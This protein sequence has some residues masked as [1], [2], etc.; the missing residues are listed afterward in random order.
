MVN[1]SLQLLEYFYFTADYSLQLA[2][3]SCIGTLYKEYAY[4]VIPLL[5]TDLGFYFSSQV[6]K[7][8]L[9]IVGSHL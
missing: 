3:H 9:E 6:Y 2:F 5:G 7:N 8:T 4:M 1:Q